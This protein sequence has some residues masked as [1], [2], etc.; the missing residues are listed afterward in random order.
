MDILVGYGIIP[1]TERLLCLYWDFLMMV[2]RVGQY[3]GVPFQGLCGFT[4]VYP[5]SPT[6]FKIVVYDVIW[7]WVTLVTG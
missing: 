7:H 3:Y 4:H 1:W 6:I 5:L 2:D